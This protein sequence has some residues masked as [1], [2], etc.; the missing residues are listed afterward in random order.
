MA[1]IRSIKPGFFLNE[2]LAALPFEWRLLF[3]GLWT[4]AD[5]DGRLED[6]PQ[7]LK[8]ALF[9]YD[10][11][12]LEEGLGRLANAGLIMRYDGN[13]QRLICIPTWAK[14]QQPHIRESV[15]DLPPPGASTVLP[16]VEHPG[17]GREGSRNGSGV[18][19]DRFERFWASYPRKVGKDAAWKEWLKRSPSE[20]LTSDIIASVRLQAAS[21][22]WKKDGGQ[23]IP[24]P[25]TWLSQGRWQDGG[26]GAGG[27]E[28]AEELWRDVCRTLGHNPECQSA[29]AHELRK[30]IAANGCLHRGV[31][32]SFG[33]H[34]QRLAAERAV[35]S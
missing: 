26:A 10:D 17:K 29:A 28:P 27:V 23:Y 13:G 8:A 16:P 35:A 15:S 30:E 31:C 20:V 34:Q 33:Q 3:V 9:P 25:R 14:H 2:T 24:H 32:Q 11:L 1:R 4:Q 6:R 18:L 19:R 22:Q 12:N 7:R 5:R 21:L